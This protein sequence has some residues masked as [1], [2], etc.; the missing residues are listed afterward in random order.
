MS[1]AVCLHDEASL[2]QP[3][4]VCCWSHAAKPLPLRV[5]QAPGQSRS[6]PLGVAAPPWLPTGPVHLPFDFCGHV[7]RLCA[8]IVQRSEALHHI[9]VSRLLFAATQA[10]SSRTHG[11]Q[12]R[13][14]PLR[15]HEG[16]LRRRRR[17][18]R[19]KEIL[20]EDSRTARSTRS[21]SSTG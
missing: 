2:S 19:S 9:D 14:T 21:E 5:I 12:A 1:S 20:A 7:Q 15:F 11:L 6:H 8:D 18:V 13:V 4:F 3:P 16:Q 10:R 17:G